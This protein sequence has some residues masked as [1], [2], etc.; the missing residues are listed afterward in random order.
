MRQM[1][2][3]NFHSKGYLMLHDLTGFTIQVYNYHLLEGGNLAK[4]MAIKLKK[5]DILY[6]IAIQ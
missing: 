5:T 6:L 1:H 3:G 4:R 2:I